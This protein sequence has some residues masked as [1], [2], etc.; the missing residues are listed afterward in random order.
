MSLSDEP[1]LGELRR[2]DLTATRCYLYRDS[3]FFH[4]TSP[5]SRISLRSAP[6]L[7][8][9][10]SQFASQDMISH[11]V[12]LVDIV[13]GQKEKEKKKRREKN[14]TTNRRS[15]IAVWA[16]TRRLISFQSVPTSPERLKACS[17][18]RD[19]S[20][21]AIGPQLPRRSPYTRSV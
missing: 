8:W 20:C 2:S 18:N 6:L 16:G 3:R 4:R 17:P 9:D 15:P 5:T 10:C 7:L 14:T 13:K 11:E 12:G 1:D 21:S 19:M